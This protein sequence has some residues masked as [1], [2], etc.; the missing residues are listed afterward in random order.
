[1]SALRRAAGGLAAALLVGLL[2]VFVHQR[3]NPHRLEVWIDSPSNGSLRLEARCQGEGASVFRHRES[4]QA[5]YQRV[6]LPLP[7]CRLGELSLRSDKAEG[8]I[9]A[10]LISRYGV[11][12]QQLLGEKRTLGGEAFLRLDSRPDR[13]QGVDLASPLTLAGEGRDTGVAGAGALQLMLV[14]LLVW[15]AALVLPRRDQEADG[16]AS[17]MKGWGAVAILAVVTMA[18]LVRTDVSLSPDEGLHV[19]TAH[20]HF[21]RWIKPAIGAVE[22]EPAYRS[23]IYGV[24]YLSAT[25]PVYVIA[26]KFAVAAWPLLQ[27]DVLGLRLFNVLLLVWVFAAAARLRYGVMFTLPLLLMPQAWYLFAYFNGDALPYALS[28]MLCVLALAH[29]TR[30][31]PHDAPSAARVLAFGGLVGMLLLSKQNYWPCTVLLAMLW[32]STCRPGLGASGWRWF[33]V[34][35]A[36]L[37]V[38]LPLALDG[39]LPPVRLAPAA[40]CL[41]AVLGLL[42]TWIL[43]QWRAR[44]GWMARRWMAGG[45]ALGLCGVIGVKMAD[46]LANNPAP[47]AAERAATALAVQEKYADKSMRPSALAEGGANSR[48]R[49]RSQGKGLIE[50]KERGWLQQSMRTAFGSYGYLDI[51]SPA[52][53]VHALQAALLAVLVLALWQAR[54]AP[55]MTSVRMA[56]LVGV[57]SVFVASALFSWTGDYQPQGRYLLSVVPML[58]LG[59]ALVGREDRSALRVVATLGFLLALVS[60]VG[61]GTAGLV[62]VTY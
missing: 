12:Q 33:C 1:M 31:T 24:S 10:V 15:V 8:R 29:W 30:A 59:L 61:V 16:P 3:I 21:E 58:G 25:D 37:V 38:T 6:R 49:M 54:P 35:S 5:R 48:Y 56:V 44:E 18:W 43:R 40:A 36:G 42:C 11:P 50:L 34:A 14:P 32:M 47:W 46:E 51:E 4:I 7:G 57:A 19:T 13:A 60:F 26:A 52:P 28:A 23:S 17:F 9:A 45:L 39:T 2:L 53:L 27:D 22:L 55:V 20:Y 62:R 41:L